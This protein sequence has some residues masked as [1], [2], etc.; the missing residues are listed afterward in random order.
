MAIPEE[1]AARTAAR[2]QKELLHWQKEKAR[3]KPKFYLIYLIG[4][5]CLIYIVDEV[6]TSLPNSILSEFNNEFFVNGLGLSVNDGLAKF[7]LM[8]LL[9]NLCLVI[10]FFY[11]TLAD[12][13]GRKPFLI[14]NTIGMLGGLLLCLWSPNLITYIIG[15][16]VI[17]FFVTPDEQ[18]VYIYE[19]APEKKRG[20]IHSII[21]GVAELGLLL[22]PLGRVTLMNNEAAL[23][24]KVFLIP[25]IV[26]A[27]GAFLS[28]L[29]ARETD[30]FID[31][32]IAYLKLTPEER[33]NIAKEK[34]DQSKKQ[35][36]FFTALKYG[37]KVPQ[38]RWIFICTMLYTLSRTIT[39]K[40]RPILEAFNYDTSAT[41]NAFWMFPLTCALIVFLTGILSD[42]IGRKRT[43]IILLSITLA[44]LILFVVG[45]Y[46]GWNEFVVGLLLGLFLGADWSNSD[47]LILMCGE[48]AP[49]NLRASAMSVQTLF[50]GAG[51]VISM[52]LSSILVEF[53]DTTFLGWYCII[54]AAPCFTLSIVFLMLKVKESKDFSLAA[55][56]DNPTQI[57]AK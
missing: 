35:G 38:L 21:K 30:P 43:S 45:C 33:A 16:F 36:G 52:G 54:L 23:W 49:T 14:F 1:K 50:Y 6:A 25:A 7:D 32:R 8:D 26:G 4:I 51:M 28:L 24:R 47:T 41:S 3:K 29:F 18:I 42:R 13:Y 22:I 17:R 15:F 48:S 44:S 34:K 40:Y 2:D 11:K 10:G 37:W 12:R 31:S 53:M 57:A 9:A 19:N 5:L 55:T 56:P 46:L 20:L 27:V 39:S